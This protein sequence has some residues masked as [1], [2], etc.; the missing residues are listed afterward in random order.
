MQFVTQPKTLTV[1]E[2]HNEWGGHLKGTRIVQEESGHVFTMSPAEWEALKA[3]PATTET[4]GRLTAPHRGRNGRELLTVPP[5]HPPLNP[6]HGTISDR[7][8]STVGITPMAAKDIVAAVGGNPS[9]ARSAIARLAKAGTLK[10]AGRGMYTL[11]RPT[12]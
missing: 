5:A 1:I 8:L 3:V 11:G 2:L 9:N 10:G 4:T 6:K 7:I 12:R